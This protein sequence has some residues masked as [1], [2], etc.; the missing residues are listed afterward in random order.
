MKTFTVKDLVLEIRN[1]IEEEEI[2]LKNK[3]IYRIDI[4]NEHNKNSSVK[5]V[6]VSKCL[7]KLEEFLYDCKFNKEV[8]DI[9]DIA[10]RSFCESNLVDKDYTDSIKEATRLVKDSF[11]SVNLSRFIL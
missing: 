11:L 6:S 4:K 1:L 9:S 8:Y 3:L 7:E 10:K 5:L 2:N